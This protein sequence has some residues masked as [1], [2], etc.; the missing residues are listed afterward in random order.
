MLVNSHQHTCLVNVRKIV[1][2]TNNMLLLVDEIDDKR[3]PDYYMVDIE[4][5]IF[6]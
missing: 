4:V 1:D 6:I 2:T 5:D 3:G